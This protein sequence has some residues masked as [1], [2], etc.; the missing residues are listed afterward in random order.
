[1]MTAAGVYRALVARCFGS[2]EMPPGDFLKLIET[3]SQ[4]DG[5]AG[6]IASFGVSAIYLSALP[7][8]TLESIYAKGPDV[9]FAGGIFPPQKAVRVDPCLCPS[10]AAPLFRYDAREPCCR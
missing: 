6:W 9:V 3:I 2:D 4:A 7:I 10:C 8:A 5:S 1:M